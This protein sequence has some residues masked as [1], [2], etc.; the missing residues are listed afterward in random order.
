MH[1][2]TNP[3][4]VS[5][6]QASVDEMNGRFKLICQELDVMV[7]R[8][9]RF[10][11]NFPKL[12]GIAW[13]EVL[14]PAGIY[15]YRPVMVVEAAISDL[16]TYVRQGSL[17]GPRRHA[18]KLR[19]ITS[20]FDAM[21]FLHQECDLLHGDLKPANILVFQNLDTRLLEL[22]L[23][24]FGLA[25]DI[26]E[27]LDPADGRMQG[28]PYWSAPETYPNS[29]SWAV[30]LHASTQDYY[31]FG[32]VLWFILFGYPVGDLK[33]GYND[34]DEKEFQTPPFKIVQCSS[35]NQ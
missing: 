1:N 17:S 33:N 14:S 32:L 21:N 25:Y 34:A 16:E 12:H 31:S 19:F 20:I 15:L 13:E 9:S 10:Y 26:T 27:H 35:N 4:G 6:V 3:Q 18:D 29:P 11:T 7:G 24:D 2:M 22:K 28:T 23:A 30:S 5:R 8:Q